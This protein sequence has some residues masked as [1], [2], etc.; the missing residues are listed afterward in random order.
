[1]VEAVVECAG[2]RQRAIT[3]KVVRHVKTATTPLPLHQIATV[4]DDYASLRH[5]AAV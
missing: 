1:M 3:V 2:S 5:T 4:R